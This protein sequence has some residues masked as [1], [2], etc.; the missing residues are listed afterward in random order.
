MATSFEALKKRLVMAHGLGFRDDPKVS[1][2]FGVEEPPADIPRLVRRMFPWP[3]GWSLDT[4][5]QPSRG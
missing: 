2:S 5:Y 3:S 4:G 1:F